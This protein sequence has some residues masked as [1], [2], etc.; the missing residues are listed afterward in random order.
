MADAPIAVRKH[1]PERRRSTSIT[2][3]ACGCCCCCCCCLHSV[4]SLIG[5]AIAP[6]IGRGRMAIYYYY[7]EETGEAV[8]HVAKAG[9]S[10]VALFWWLLLGLVVFGF[11]ASAFSGPTG[12]IV[13]AVIIAMVLPALQ[14]LSALVTAIVVATSTRYDK[15]YQFKQLGKMTLGVILGTVLGILVMV[16]IGVALS[17][18]RF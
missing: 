17:G 1:E 9:V 14:L 10:A 6:T 16:G 18:M 7:D 13:G 15:M 4:G 12:L 2:T 3:L 8:P 5:A 11:F